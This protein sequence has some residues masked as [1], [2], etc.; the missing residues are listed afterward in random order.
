MNEKKAIDTYL[1]E[2]KQ[3]RLLTDDEERRLAERIQQGDQKALAQLTTANLGYVVSLAHQH[4]GNGLS[5]EDLIS[6]GNI[7]LMRAAARYDGS[8]GK[9]FVTFAAP[10]IREAMR[11]AI[12]QQ[13][14]LYRIPRDAS[15]SHTEKLRSRALSIDAPVGGSHNL[16]LGRVVANPHAAD[17]A[18]IME[19]KALADE[20]A[21]LVGRLEGREQQVAAYL[22]GIDGAPLTMAETAAQMGLKRERVRQIRNKAVRQLCRMTTNRELRKYLS[23]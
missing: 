10:Y 20:L 9:R 5:T 1:N 16:S 8:R 19:E 15:D 12:E 4:A 2:I 7:G 21:T 22:Y 13:A 23:R 18:S 3:E 17:P 14:G 6:E 11:Q